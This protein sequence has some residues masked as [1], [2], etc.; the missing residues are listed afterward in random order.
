MVLGVPVVGKRPS[1]EVIT[2][3]G[4]ELQHRPLG[5]WIQAMPSAMENY[6][7]FEKQH[8]EYCQLEYGVP[9]DHASGT[10]H[11]KLSSVGL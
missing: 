7:P 11:Y 2:A 9:S 8:L 10:G 4:Q 1:M 5:S 6:M 3:S